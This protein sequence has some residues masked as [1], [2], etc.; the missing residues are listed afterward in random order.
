MIAENRFFVECSISIAIKIF[1]DGLLERSCHCGQVRSIYAD[2]KKRNTHEI[3]GLW[4]RKRRKSAKVRW[5]LWK[6]YYSQ[7]LV[8]LHGTRYRSSLSKTYFILYVSHEMHIWRKTEDYTFF[9]KKSEK[10]VQN[11]SNLCRLKKFCS[12]HHI[13]ATTFNFRNAF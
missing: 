3:E 4:P 13:F 1:I 12:P 10:M 8:F 9:G 6:K 5:W 7:P 11:C 2:K